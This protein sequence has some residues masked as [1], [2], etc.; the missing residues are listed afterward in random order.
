MHLFSSPI[1]EQAFGRQLP[2]PSAPTKSQWTGQFALVA[3][4]GQVN[5][6]VVVPA[7]S[8]P[9]DSGTLMHMPSVSC[10]V[11]SMASVVVVFTT[12]FAP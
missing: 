12:G 2:C 7:R 5:L 8:S 3:D 9:E 11:G 1:E 10:V 4:E 6:G